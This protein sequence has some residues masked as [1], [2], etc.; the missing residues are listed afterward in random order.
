MSKTIRIL[1]VTA[2]VSLLLVAT[3]FTVAAQEGGCPDGFMLHLAHDHD[4][5]HAG[6]LHVGTDADQ[7]GDGYICVKHVTSSVEVHVHIDNAV[8]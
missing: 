1:F 2:M 5:H 7:N 4:E 3:V 6:H 8:K